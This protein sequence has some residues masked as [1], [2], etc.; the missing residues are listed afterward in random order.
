MPFTVASTLTGAG[1]TRFGVKKNLQLLWLTAVA[2]PS[3][4][5]EAEIEA[6]VEITGAVSE[7]AGFDASDNYAELPDLVSDFSGKV[8]NGASLSD[9]SMTFWLDSTAVGDA[10][11]TFTTGDEGYVL[12]CPWGLED[13]KPALLWSM[14][15]GSVLPPI[16]TSGASI[17]VVALAPRSLNKVT[18][19]TSTP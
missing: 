14:T 8:W 19:P 2:D 11:D 9:S 10:Y 12:Q 7:T 16:S 6:G 5:T 3:A 1:S 4:P 13:A 18:L 15:V 17:V